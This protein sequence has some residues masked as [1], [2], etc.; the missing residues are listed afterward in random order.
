[1]QRRDRESLGG[2][3]LGPVRLVPLAMAVAATF[4]GCVDDVGPVAAVRPG[5]CGAESGTGQVRFAEECCCC[6]DGPCQDGLFCNGREACNCW[7]ECEAPRS[8]YNVCV[9]GDPC[10]S[11]V[12]DEA[13]DFCPHTPLPGSGCP[14][15]DDTVCDDRDA[16]TADRCALA[17][18]TCR[19]SA[20]ACDDGD[21]CTNDWCH[22]AHG[23]L[24][25]WDPFRCQGRL[26][27]AAGTVS[28]ERMRD[29][30]RYGW[31]FLPVSVS[32]PGPAAGTAR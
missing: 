22:P 12:C 32:P 29:T 15:R 2:I 4:A 3:A 10:T 31:R 30:T 9:D 20:V 27:P 8:M 1:M 5:P 14:C 13:H 26:P 17:G 16:C 19:H 23:C 7:G 6:D 18:G 21:E 11:D 24:T 28:H 25:V